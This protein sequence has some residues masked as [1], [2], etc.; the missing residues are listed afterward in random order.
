ML[1][2]H[3][4]L[5]SLPSSTLGTGRVVFKYMVHLLKSPTASFRDAEVR[6]DKGEDTEHREEDVRAIARIVD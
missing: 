1:L 2:H 3:L 5:N 6:P 4:I